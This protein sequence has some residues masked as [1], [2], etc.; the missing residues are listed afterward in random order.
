M[1]YHRTFVLSWF[2]YSAAPE[3]ALLSETM[4]CLLETVKSTKSIFYTLFAQLN[5]L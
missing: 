4:L 1:K 5:V 2:H 3:L